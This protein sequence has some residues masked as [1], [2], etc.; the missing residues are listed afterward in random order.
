MGHHSKYAF[1]P[2]FAKQGDAPIGKPRR[3]IITQDDV[4]AA[5]AAGYEA[6]RDD[7]VAQA[8]RA[9]AE[10]LR[11]IARQMQLMLGRQADEAEGLR[12]DAVDVV[13]TATRAIAGRAL[14]DFG[15]A[16]VEALITDAVSH[17]RDIP[18]MVIRV[19]PELA[20]RTQAQL[21]GAAHEAGFT[22][23][24][25]IRPDADAQS[26][27]CTLD[28]GDGL[29]VH[30]RAAALAAIEDAARTWQASADAEGLSIDI[31]SS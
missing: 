15:Q 16:H 17:L 25:I 30:S 14:D 19:A 24:I 23:D 5:R 1:E 29:I 28:W 26:G 10:A 6:G 12:A 21:I 22:G 4:E 13:L 2:I 3:K 18:R 7:S 8:E 9:S 31:G 20:E 11:A 27:D